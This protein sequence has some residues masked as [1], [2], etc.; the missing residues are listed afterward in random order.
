[1]KKT[2]MILLL[3]SVFLGCSKK[4]EVTPP[5]T[6]QG[7]NLKFVKSSKLNSGETVE[8]AFNISIVM[9]WKADGKNFK[10]NGLNDGLY[11]YDNTSKQSYKADY[12]YQNIRTETYNLPAGQYFITIITDSSESPKLAYSYTNFTVE[13]GNYLNLKKDVSSMSSYTYTAW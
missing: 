7:V 11:A 2:V 13:K 5:E 12:S 1:M 4:D 6:K 8:N 10:Y 9:I 3:M